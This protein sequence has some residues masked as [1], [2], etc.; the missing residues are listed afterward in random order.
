MALNKN[1]IYVS[2]IGLFFI[3]ES[4]GCSLYE[5]TA[6]GQNV[7]EEM[8]ILPSLN[9]CG[10]VGAFDRILGGKETAMQEFPWTALLIY[11]DETDPD[12]YRMGCGG[13]LINRYYVFTAAHCGTSTLSLVRLGE[14][15]ISSEIDIA[16]LNKNIKAI[17]APPIKDIKICRQ[18]IHPKYNESGVY[19]NDIALLELERKVD[20]TPYIS[21]ICLPI[22]DEQRMNRYNDVSAYIT[23]WGQRETNIY[24]EVKLKARVK[25]ITNDKCESEYLSKSKIN[26][27][28]K[29]MCAIGNEMDTGK[30]D[31]GGSLIVMNTVNGKINAYLAGITSGGLQKRINEKDASENYNRI[32]AMGIYVHVGSY[33]KWII[34][35]LGSFEK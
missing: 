26:I 17:A 8:R 5:R 27:S 14:W 21:P 4:V 24:S 22:N 32:A 15:N 23:G 29:L 33:M 2:L 16:E 30:G 1:L 19:D 3:G 35:N 28:E 13:S 7:M 34:E 12:N 11:V 6:S 9:E 10:H 20:Y 25:I 18:I 31:S